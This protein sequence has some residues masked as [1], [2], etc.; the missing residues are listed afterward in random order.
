MIAVCFFIQSVRMYT[1]VDKPTT[2]TGIKRTQL[3]PDDK[4]NTKRPRLWGNFIIESCSQGSMPFA[5]SGKLKS[6]AKPISIIKIDSD[7]LKKTYSVVTQNHR[8]ESS[9]ANKSIDSTANTS[10]T[11][12]IPSR[13]LSDASG[14]SKMLKRS[15]STAIATTPTSAAK[16]SSIKSIKAMTPQDIK[17]TLQQVY[18][19]NIKKIDMRNSTG[20]QNPT[21]QKRTEKRS[22][23]MHAIKIDKMR[24]DSDNSSAFKPPK[25]TQES[26]ESKWDS[27][28][29]ILSSTAAKSQKSVEKKITPKGDV[30]KKLQ[31]VFPLKTGTTTEFN[32]GK[33]ISASSTA[34][35]VKTIIRTKQMT[36]AEPPGNQRKVLSLPF[37]NDLN[38]TIAW[39]RQNRIGTLSNG[40]LTFERNEFGMIE[41]QKVPTI[42]SANKC[43]SKLKKNK[44]TDLLLSN[45]CNH[46]NFD[47]CFNAVLMRWGD[48]FW[49]NQ[50]TPIGYHSNELK[51][52]IRSCIKKHHHKC[53]L[54]ALG[55]IQE[56][57]AA[58]KYFKEAAQSMSSKFEWDTYLNY[59]NSMHESKLNVA[60]IK[61][62]FNP[63]PSAPNPFLVGQKLE[64]IDPKNCALF[65]VCTVVDVR[66]YRIKLHFDGYHMAYDF[67]TNADSTQIFPIG[68]CERT[69]REL[70]P[71]PGYTPYFKW[72]EYLNKTNSIAAPRSNFSHL[73]TSSVCIIFLAFSEK[74]IYSFFCTYSQGTSHN[75]FKIGMKLEADDIKNTRKLCVATIG[76][77]IDN[78]VLIT[79]DGL[80]RQ[81]N[82]WADVDSPYLH[83]VNWH[84]QHGYS[85]QPPGGKS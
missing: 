12:R 52:I 53:N 55:D 77:V 25:I 40:V 68:W 35:T 15:Y 49:M 41:L 20:I 36:T 42:T 44:K 6:G 21:S 74:G 29:E 73:N 60:P 63:M 5:N 75:P 57:M 14:S 1:S 48:N 84:L 32:R 80:D 56:A 45:Q 27:L 71:P 38:E 22:K 58:S 3:L 50:T 37:M 69:A 8:V 85:I 9:V 64:A 46:E 81:S 28:T 11:N 76:D 7:K 62:F 18:E 59:W 23:S 51:E 43:A 30:G 19:Q 2:E 10:V 47:V 13:R 39:N 79:L 16:S 67:W 33:S 24:G 54:V 83:P 17:E 4:D 82:Y 65:C 72:S 34:P 70:Q 66:G 78:H 26:F 31:A 61:F